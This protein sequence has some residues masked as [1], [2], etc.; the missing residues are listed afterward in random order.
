[1]VDDVVPWSPA[2]RRGIVPGVKI[3][4][5]NRQPTK[6]AAD[7]NRA[8]EGLKSGTIVNLLVETPDGVTRIVNVKAEK[9]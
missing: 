4:E 7:F 6:S 8:I 5:V 9:N 1:V 2:Q 3:D